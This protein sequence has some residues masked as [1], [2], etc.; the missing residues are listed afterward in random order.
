MHTQDLYYALART[1][2]REAEERAR[3]YRIAKQA[4][5]ARRTSASAPQTRQRRL[6]RRLRPVG[7]AA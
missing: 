4:R 1:S 6:T 7:E 5:K 2:Q 3:I